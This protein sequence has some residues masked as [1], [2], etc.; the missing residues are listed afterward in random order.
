MVDAAEGTDS[1]R[2]LTRRDT[3]KLGLAAAAA[4]ASRAAGAAP[5]RPQP[6]S[7]GFNLPGWVDRLDGTAPTTTVLDRLHR[8]GFRAVRLPVEPGLIA[9]SNGL[10]GRRLLDAIESAVRRLDRHGFSVTLDMHPG[11]AVLEALRH[12]PKLA[13]DTVNEA[14][15]RLAAVVAALPAD[16]VFAEL[17]NE[18]PL[19][20][21]VW[22]ALRAR[23]A[24]TIRAACPHHGLIWGPAR[25][26]GIWE[27]AGT[28]P[29]DDGNA[30]AAV[31]YYTPMGFTHQCENWD[32]SSPLSRIRSLPFPADLSTPAVSEL[33][34]RFRSQGDQDDAAFL[35]NEFSSPWTAARIAADFADAGHW[36]KANGQPVILN[37]FG[38]L[39]FCTDPASRSAWT[40]AV[41]SAA[42]ANGIGWTYWELDHGFGFIRDRRSTDGF[43]QTLIAALLPG[44]A[45]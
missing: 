30:I 2:R 3:L 15:R 16:T 39:G 44:S 21:P 19:E 29:L 27:L 13:G 38:A 42:E 7:H 23:L 31:H 37:E 36:A 34:D 33:L 28:P 17:L 5:A 22:L 26:Q 11:D 18:P 43:D 10:D 24:A 12:D 9:R 8:L 35:R 32:A 6:P 40:R 4:S 25:Y 41:R 20:R 14:W 45:P 1:V